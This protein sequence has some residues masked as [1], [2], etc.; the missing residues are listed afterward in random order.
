MFSKSCKYA[1]R[2]SLLLALETDEK[3]KIG[4][5]EIAV[6]LDVPKHFLAKI[7]QQ[8]SKFRLIS[9]TKGPNGGFFMSKLNKNASLLSIITCIDGDEQFKGCILGLPN[10]SDKHPCSFHDEYKIYRKKLMDSFKQ[11][12]I[13]E[14]AKRIQE[15]NFKL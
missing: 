9:S 4:V 2:A 3:N 10:C 15:F 13:E 1:I 14:S 5:D 6:R 7:L 8:L 11:E 12:T